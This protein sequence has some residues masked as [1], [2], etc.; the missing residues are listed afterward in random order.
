[1]AGGRLPP[2]VGERVAVERGQLA[3]R[4]QER[5][6][7]LSDHRVDGAAVAHGQRRGVLG[8]Q[9]PA[10]KRRPRATPAAV[11]RTSVRC[12]RPS[13]RPIRPRG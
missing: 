9:V 2:Q 10:M 7:A 4:Q 5:R 3:D 1:M 8:R 11:A 13:A 12:S 6:A